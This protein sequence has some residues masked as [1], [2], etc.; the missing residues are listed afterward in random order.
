MHIT[1]HDI[2][3]RAV[4]LVNIFLMALPILLLNS[5][6]IYNADKEHLSAF[7]QF[8]LFIVLYVFFARVLDAFKVSYY[9]VSKMIYGQGMSCFIIDCAAYVVTSLIYKSFNNIL[10][11]FCV[12]A[13]Q[14]AFVFAWCFAVNKIYFCVTPPKDTVVIFDK[15]IDYDVFSNDGNFYKKYNI[16]K[17]IKIEDWLCDNKCIDGAKTVLLCGLSSCDKNKV[18]VYAIQN[19]ISV[20]LLPSVSDIILSGA[21]T[22]NLLHLPMMSANRYNPNI[23][24]C[25][26]KRLMDILISAVM[27]IILSPL[28]LL[29]ALLIKTGDGGPVFYRQTRLTLN[30]KPFNIIKFRSMKVDAEKD[31]IAVL[32]SG[33]NDERVTKIG[34]FIRKYRIDELPQLINILAGSLSLVGPRPE[35]PEI[36][37]KYSKIIPEFSLRLQA[38]AGL[39]GYAQV[40]GKYN[41]K[42][43]DKLVMDLIYISKPGIFNDIAIMFSTLKVIFEK[44]STEGVDED[45]LESSVDAISKI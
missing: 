39:T 16:I 14:L 7:L 9:R 41:S 5:F 8:A 30:G 11:F 37:E 28:M 44:E 42:P 19:D 31:G 20:L 4:K 25:I 34:K 15:N 6:N 43:Y 24:Y 29:I 1:K 10:P 33:E 45:I 3:L 2:W 38:K 27:L 12:F 32:S 26:I 23:E 22:L 17:K 36:F 21:K 18:L 40:F 35:R 13:I